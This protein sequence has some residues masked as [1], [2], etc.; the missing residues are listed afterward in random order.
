[1][2]NAHLFK[3]DTWKNRNDFACVYI[4]L[5]DKELFSSSQIEKLLK[6]ALG[7][8]SFANFH[9][10]SLPQLKKKYSKNAKY[11]F[12][13]SVTRKA[14]VL[15][16]F[17]KSNNIYSKP[18]RFSRSE[19]ISIPWFKSVTHSMNSINNSSIHFWNK[20]IK[21]LIR[22]CTFLTHELEQLHQ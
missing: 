5:S 22:P 13:Y 19:C 7:I 11:S 12:L 10:S 21:N 16:F 6:K 4:I 1:M 15:D 20:L 17:Q 18:I 3:T 9:A 14:E 8:I 2:S